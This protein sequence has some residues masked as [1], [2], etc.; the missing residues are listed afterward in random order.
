MEASDMILHEEYNFKHQQEKLKY[1][2][3]N[4]SGNGYWH[5]F[6]LISEPNVIWSEMQDSDLQM[7]EL[8]RKEIK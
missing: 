5:Q 7:I 8:T 6:E 1:V 4:F 2:G 3:Y